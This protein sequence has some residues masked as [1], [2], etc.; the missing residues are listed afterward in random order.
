MIGRE[1]NAIEKRNLEE[2]DTKQGRR[3][4]EKRRRGRDVQGLPRAEH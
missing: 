2:N 3:R 4:R 1:G